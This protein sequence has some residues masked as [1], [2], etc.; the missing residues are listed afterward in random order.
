M[1]ERNFF[2]GN[3]NS[4]KHGPSKNI[5]I[6]IKCSRGILYINMKCGGSE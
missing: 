6:K 5:N 2:D 1:A 3:A 4:G